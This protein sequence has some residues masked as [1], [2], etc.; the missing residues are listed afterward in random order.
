MTK[1]AIVASLFVHIAVGVLLGVKAHGQSLQA[2]T[3]YLRSQ[4]TQLA[5]QYF[6][7]SK[8][9]NR[10]QDFIIQFKQVPTTAIQAELAKSFK[11][12]SYIPDHA[13][14][15]RGV[16]SDVKK[17]VQASESVHAL[18]PF[19]GFMKL[20]P[21]LGSSSV[22][23]QDE[24]LKVL[25]KCYRSSGC[26]DLQAKLQDRG[27]DIL[28]HSNN[29]F[30]VVLQ[31]KHLLP[32]SQQL[33][34]EHIQPLVEFKN[35]AL[36]LSDEDQSE[37]QAQEKKPLDGTESGTLAMGFPTAWEKGYTG[38]NQIGAFADTGLDTGDMETLHEDLRG[39]VISGQALGIYSYS[40]EDP[41]GHGTHVAGSIAG[42][43][44]HSGGVL[45][46][47]AY[48]STLV[49]QGM[50]SDR[51]ENF[52]VPSKLS[53]LFDG[54]LK[55]G[56]LVHNNSWGSVLSPGSYD[57]SAAEVDDWTYHHPE[58]LVVFAAGNS[59]ADKD[60]NGRIDGGSLATPG[61][62]KNALTVGASENVTYTG[63]V[64][65]PLKKLNAA[66]ELWPAEP[67]YSSHPSDNLNGLA[68]FSSRGPTMDGRIK[69]DLVAPGSN[70][71]SLRSQV[72][73]AIELWGAYDS[74]YV[75]SGGTSM[76]APLVSG[77]ALI[78][79]EIL[80][81]KRGITKP[82][83][84]L[85]KAL[86]MNSTVDMFPGQFGEVGEENGQEILSHRPNADQGFGRLAVDRL[87][88]ASEGAM[89]WDHTGIQQGQEFEVEF[90]VP[91]G[92]RVYA[93]LV[94]SDPPAT[95][96]AGKALVNDLDLDFYREGELISKN[97]DRLNNFETLEIGDLSGGLYK[98]KIRA[99]RVLQTGAEKQ[100]FALVISVN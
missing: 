99:H 100:P 85:M 58:M 28:D 97:E 46:G 2:P 84:A 80:L 64:Q 62:S 9:S 98:I 86:L 1:T 27:L 21:D 14:V 15:I 51:L 68:M 67:L 88:E 25:I 59:G 70:I 22:F 95:P 94:W 89:L 4:T 23:N 63:G 13:F 18:I 11:I 30:A 82:S 65:V 36:P 16:S 24:Y 10:S 33:S 57:A 91:A 60:K 81:K 5:D 32:I 69:P 7:F 77:A 90:T 17:Y 40:W 47:G 56:A 3:L 45:K 8:S 19:E 50:W 37:M 41:N 6:S 38:A 29:D 26:A 55:E 49:A 78:C 66:R 92:K 61:T 87:V 31:R 52:T 12:L 75:W 43:G 54:A 39:R 83:A 76:A 72:E 34:V 44:V 93:N 53:V 79:R 42:R 74:N 73:S 71:L 96:N 48:N 35:F 20:S